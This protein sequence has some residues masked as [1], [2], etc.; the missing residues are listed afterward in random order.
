MCT[1]Q[2]LNTAPPSTELTDNGAATYSTARLKSRSSTQGSVSTAV[3]GATPA[4]ER[5][6]SLV[7]SLQKHHPQQLAMIRYALGVARQAGLLCMLLMIAKIVLGSPICEY[8]L[9][10][11]A[12]KLRRGRPA[13]QR[14]LR[15]WKVL[16]NHP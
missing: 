6:N 13:A 9:Q 3:V 7:S 2:E 12:I 15:L 1:V 4:Y 11:Y 14:A 8:M 16:G 5:S 10:V